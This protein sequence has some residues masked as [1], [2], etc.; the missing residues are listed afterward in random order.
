MRRV[1]AAGV[2]VAVL[3][4]LVGCSGDEAPVAAPSPSPSPTPT[5]TAT[6]KPKPAPAPKPAPKPAVN[7]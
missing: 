7:P 1:T 2:A 5:V 4:G 6:A 3:A